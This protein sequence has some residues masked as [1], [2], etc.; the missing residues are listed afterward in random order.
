MGATAAG[1]TAG[2]EV[3]GSGE[4]VFTATNAE[5]AKGEMVVG[6]ERSTTFPSE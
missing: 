2:D 6:Q 1:K 3:N 5:N 4:R